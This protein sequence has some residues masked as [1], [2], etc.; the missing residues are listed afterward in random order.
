MQLAQDRVKSF[1]RGGEDSERKIADAGQKRLSTMRGRCGQRTL[2]T[3]HKFRR[4]NGLRTRLRPARLYF[5]FA[6]HQ[7]EDEIHGFSR[8]TLSP[9][10]LVSMC[11]FYMRTLRGPSANMNAFRADFFG[12]TTP[13]NL[14]M[15]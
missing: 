8:T 6:K 15:G 11:G 9:V 3:R 12:S 1:R 10:S 5:Y 13:S 7:R 4:C 2:H 14:R